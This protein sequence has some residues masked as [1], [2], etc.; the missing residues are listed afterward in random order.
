MVGSRKKV[1][2]TP[3]EYGGFYN[4]QSKPSH[5]DEIHFQSTSSYQIVFLVQLTSVFQ[6]FWE[7]PT[8]TKFQ[9]HTRHFCSVTKGIT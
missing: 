4:N 8:V 7:M 5:L 2:K 6:S 1:T 9:F 3:S